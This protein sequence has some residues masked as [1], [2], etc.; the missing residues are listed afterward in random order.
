MTTVAQI[1]R[2]ESLEDRRLLSARILNH[3]LIVKGTPARDD[4]TVDA[5]VGCL[6]WYC[7]AP[8][9]SVFDG[10]RYRSFKPAGFYTL[11]VYGLGGNDRITL[12]FWGAPSL[13]DG[14]AGNDRITS[15]EGADTLLGGPGNDQLRGAEGD[16]LIL[17]GAGDDT[18]VGGTGD[19]FL[20]GQAGRDRL[21]GGPR[22]DTFLGTGPFVDTLW[23]GDDNDTLIGGTGG[24][25]ELD[26]GAGLDS[27][28]GV[29][30]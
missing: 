25:D 28:N 8:S 14:G 19:N 15:G 7:P 26:G 21:L 9:I 16:D 12:H 5:I 30:E 10:L 2:M 6:P 24:G 29:L 4:I 11:K 20:Q 17:G 3:V 22:M 23:G 1:C 13:L 18:L 27:V